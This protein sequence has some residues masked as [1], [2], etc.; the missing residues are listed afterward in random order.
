MIVLVCLWDYRETIYGCD[1]WCDCDACTVVCVACAFAERVWV[2]EGDGNANVGY[3][4][5]VVVVN[6]GH[7]VGTSGCFLPIKKISLTRGVVDGEEM[8][9]S[10]WEDWVWA[11]HILWE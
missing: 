1:G 10:G 11:L 9:V 7:L 3:G 6:N 5:G 4:L 8:G 2:C